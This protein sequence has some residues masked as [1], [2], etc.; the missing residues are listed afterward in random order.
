MKR[1]D[2][3]KR[4]IAK[5]KRRLVSWIVLTIVFAMLDFLQVLP[6]MQYVTLLALLY[7][8]IQL[9]ILIY[10]MYLWSQK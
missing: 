4:T 1:R 10:L 7:S 8:I 5:T 2:E 3:I 6:W 9:G